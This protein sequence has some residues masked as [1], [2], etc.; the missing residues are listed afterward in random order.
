[1]DDKY[2]HLIIKHK[3]VEMCRFNS[4]R[5]ISRFKTIQILYYSNIR[6]IYIHDDDHVAL[7]LD[8]VFTNGFMLIPDLMNCK[9]ILNKYISSIEN[10]R[11]NKFWQKAKKISIDEMLSL[12][13]VVRFFGNNLNKNEAFKKY[14]KE[15][16]PIEMLQQHVTNGSKL[17]IKRKKEMIDE[18]ELDE[19]YQQLINKAIDFEKPYFM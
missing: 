12:M 13:E 2:E 4:T 19:E 5:T 16:I 15:I 8:D 1:M 10:R 7:D 18:Y 11:E 14:I 6:K 3:G 9:D 17:I